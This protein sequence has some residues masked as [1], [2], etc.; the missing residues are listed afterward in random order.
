[1][2]PNCIASRRRYC[3]KRQFRTR[4]RNSWRRA[5]QTRLGVAYGTLAFAANENKNYEL[6][7]KALESRAKLLHRIR[8]PACYFFERASAFDHLRDY[9]QACADYHLFLDAANGKYPDQEWK[10]RHRLIWIEPKK[11]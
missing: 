2:T 11:H 1:M 3:S 4:N 7:V 9:K 6:A 8:R 10:A 5:D